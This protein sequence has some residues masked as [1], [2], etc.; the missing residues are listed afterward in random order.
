MAKALESII[1]LEP[2]FDN[3]LLISFLF[4][5]C[6]WL[7]MGPSEIVTAISHIFVQWPFLFSYTD[8]RCDANP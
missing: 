1:P 4:F 3:S 8:Y 2:D 5:N 6:W 7:N